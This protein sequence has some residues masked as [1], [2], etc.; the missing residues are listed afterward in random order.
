MVM[1]LILCVIFFI[2][3]IIHFNWVLGGTFGFA[4]SLPTNEKGERVIN[5]KK[6]ESGVVGTGLMA[7]AFFYLVKS[8]MIDIDL[9]EW[10]MNYVSWIIPAIFILRAIGEFKY[11]GFFKRIKNTEFGK[12][13]TK[14]YSPLCL[15]VGVIGILI[16]LKNGYFN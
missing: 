12:L 13:D 8:G 2:L 6:M 11:I 16:E 7:F 3:S 9:P 14:F 15:S 1:P 5:P 10:V 4:A